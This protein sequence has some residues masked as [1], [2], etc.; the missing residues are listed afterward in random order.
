MYES[1]LG[2]EWLELGTLSRWS[3]SSLYLLGLSSPPPREDAPQ[4][5]VR[6]RSRLGVARTRDPKP[7]VFILSLLREAFITTHLFSQPT[8]D[9]YSHSLGRILALSS[10]ILPCAEHDLSST[11]ASTRSYDLGHKD[12]AARH[13]FIHLACSQL[14]FINP[15][16]PSGDNPL[17]R[18]T[19][20]TSFATSTFFFQTLGKSFGFTIR[21]WPLTIS[22]QLSLCHT[23]RSLPNNPFPCLW[24]KDLV[25]HLASYRFRS[26][27]PRSFTNSRGRERLDPF[28]YSVSTVFTQHSFI[29]LG[30]GSHS[31]PT[32]FTLSFPSQVRW[33]EQDSFGQHYIRFILSTHP[34]HSLSDSWEGVCVLISIITSTF[35]FMLRHSCIHYPFHSFPVF[36]RATELVLLRHNFN[37]YLNFLSAH[38]TFFR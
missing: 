2:W 38:I 25:H 34:S 37:L 30:Q 6:V 9:L 15:S 29:S 24:G 5:D 28:Y 11:F 16:I 20:L 3:S 22:T 27:H 26:L 10:T 31:F 1:A 17:A 21:L 36:C 35:I 18:L 4:A 8:H 32:L 23:Q 7:L 14:Q 33:Q 19:F 13:S 12:L